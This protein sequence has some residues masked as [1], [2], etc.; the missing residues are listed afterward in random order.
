MN[1][2]WTRI[3][4]QG[5]IGFG[6]TAQFLV[7]LLLCSYV[8]CCMIAAKP[9]GPKAYVSFAYHCSRWQPGEEDFG[10][11]EWVN[12]HWRPIKDR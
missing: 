7:F 6:K 2:D 11:Q 5:R 3:K 4:E 10:P 12:G 9:V 1:W 8:V